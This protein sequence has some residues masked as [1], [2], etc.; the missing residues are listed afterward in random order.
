VTEQE[1]KINAALK[2]IATDYERLNDR[3]VRFA[4]RE[5]DRVRHDITDLLADYADKATGKITKRRL[6]ALLRE[7]ESIEKA[8]RTNGMSA[9]EDVIK[10][11]SSYTTTAVNGAMEQTLGAAAIAGVTLD[12]IDRDV[13][14]YV[15]N[16]FA[17]DGLQLSDRVWR[18]AGEQRDELNRVLRSSII[19][20]DAMTQMIARVR[21][22]YANDTWKIE[23][24]VRTE[25]ATAQRVGEAYYAQRSDVVK[26]LKLHEG[27]CGRKDHNR[28]RCHILAQEDRHGLGAGVFLPDDS[29]YFA[30]HPNCTSYYTY[31]LADKYA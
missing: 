6:N 3:Q 4:I 26:A 19:R 14:R 22:V 18:F 9:L 12:V 8:V 28:H 5:I 1:R 17:D 27:T 7:L 13:F 2:R 16:R 21:E 29:E 25:G 11:S 10:E 31:V 20:G 30:P 15:V 24:L 23:R